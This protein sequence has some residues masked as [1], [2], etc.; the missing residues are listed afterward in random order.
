MI[1]CLAYALRFWELNPSYKLHYNSDHVVNSKINLEPTYLPAEE[2]GYSY[3]QSA[4]NG[5][6][7]N[8]ELELLKKYF[9]VNRIRI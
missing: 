1:N 2:F 9:N 4:F 5:L 6:L 7:D 8:Y 3:F